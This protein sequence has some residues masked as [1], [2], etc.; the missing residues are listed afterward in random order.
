MKGTLSA[1]ADALLLEAPSSVQSDMDFLA[2]SP[3]T[4]SASTFHAA[5]TCPVCEAA[6][7]TRKATIGLTS[8][9]LPASLRMKEMRRQP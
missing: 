3:Q 2:S 1:L 4:L 8:R 5:M 7:K 9:S 6:L